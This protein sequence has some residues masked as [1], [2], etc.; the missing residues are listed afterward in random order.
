MDHHC[1]KLEQNLSTYFR[2]VKKLGEGSFGKVY[3]AAVEDQGYAL[4][5]Y[6][7]PPLVAIKHLHNIDSIEKDVIINEIINLKTFILRRSVKYYGCFTNKDGLYIVMELIDGVDL[8]DLVDK[9]TLSTNDKLFI[10]REL[11]LAIAECHKVGLVHRDIKPENVMVQFQANNMVPIIKLIDYG[12]SCNT[13]ANPLWEKCHA[14]MGTRPYYDKKIVLGNIDSM[15]QGDWWAFGQI[16]TLMFT[17]TLLYEQA[18]DKFDTLGPNEYIHIPK[19]LHRLLDGLT[20]PDITQN[21]RPTESDILRILNKNMK[22]TSPPP[23]PP[24]QAPAPS[25]KRKRAKSM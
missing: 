23:P 13:N 21:E 5:P 12:L 10:A 15:K 4:L 6:G 11:A 14:R 17:Y 16:I 8:F 3:T 24:Q 1:I 2:L 19:G 7:A 9:N 20:D 18:K 22:K 25:M